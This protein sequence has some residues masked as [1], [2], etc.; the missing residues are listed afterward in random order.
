MMTDSTA[1][2]APIA[3]PCLALPLAEEEETGGLM[4]SGG[5][6]EVDAGVVAEGLM[7]SGG[8]AEIDAVVV[9]EKTI[10]I[11]DTAGLDSG[12]VAISADVVD[13]DADDS[14]TRH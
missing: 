8:S 14:M 4:V 11:C 2:G 13:L 5:S 3:S 1:I 6:V 10:V 7:V 12:D 9:A